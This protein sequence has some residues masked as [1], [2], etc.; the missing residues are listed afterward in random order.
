[1][2]FF[3][4]MFSFKSD[5]KIVEEA[6]LK[7]LTQEIISSY[8][9]RFYFSDELSLITKNL[10]E[11]Y[12]YPIIDRTVKPILQLV[13]PHI[14]D[15][16][17]PESYKP[18][19]PYFIICHTIYYTVDYT[20]YLTVY[21]AI[22]QRIFMNLKKIMIFLRRLFLILTILIMKLDYYLLHLQPVRL[23]LTNQKLKLFKLLTQRSMTI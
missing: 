15:T 4:N 9:K 3:A 14:K 20:I 7:P 21:F 6:E 11:N 18:L 13:I 19:V 17:G 8:Q 16:L 5:K 23:K 22:Y 12:Q 1:M 2:R 10:T